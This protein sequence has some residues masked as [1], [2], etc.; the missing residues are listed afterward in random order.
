[1][2]NQE[3]V[4]AN[5]TQK[6][7][8]D[9]DVQ[10]DHLISARLTDLVIIT[11]KIKENKAKENLQNCRLRRLGRPR[12]K[13]KMKGK[14]KISTQKRKEKKEKRKIST[15]KRKESENKDKYPEK[16]RKE[17]ENKDKYPEK[18]RKESEKER[19]E[20][21]KGIKKTTVEHECDNDINCN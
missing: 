5:E 15:Q 6:R 4:L 3:S 21:S 7:L 12:S 1:M 17:S 14:T 11:K 20:L 10:T 16:K 9:F 8:W 13:T 19:V 2:H 18:K